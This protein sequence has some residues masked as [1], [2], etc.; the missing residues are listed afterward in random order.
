MKLFIYILVFI[1]FNLSAQN[2]EAVDFKDGLSQSTVLSMA[3]DESGF[4]WLGTADGLNRFDGISI[5]TFRS[6]DEN[7]ICGNEIMDIVN[8]GHGNLWT[9]A[10]HNG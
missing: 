9:P 1:G 2:F 3:Q 4:V 7:G 8:D 6:S 10:L 5:R